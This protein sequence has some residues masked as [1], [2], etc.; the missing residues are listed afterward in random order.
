VDAVTLIV[1]F[2]LLIIPTILVK[3]INTVKAIEFR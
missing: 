3:K 1:C 2:V